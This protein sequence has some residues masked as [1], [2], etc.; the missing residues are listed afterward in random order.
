MPVFS[1][2]FNFDAMGTS[3]QHYWSGNYILGAVIG[4]SWSLYFWDLYL[5]RRQRN[6]YKTSKTIPD[7][8]KDVISPETF[9][10]SRKYKLDTSKY[11][12]IHTLFDQILDTSLLAVAAFPFLWNVS[13]KIMSKYGYGSHYEITQSLIFTGILYIITYA[14]NIPWKCYY[15]FVIEQKHGFNKMTVGFF[16]KDQFKHLALKLVLIP[17]ILAGMIH[18]IKIGGKYFYFYVWLFFFLLSLF[19]MA[20]YPTVIA[21]L[22]DKYTP[23]DQ[24]E[25][26]SKIEKLAS[27]LK[28]PLSQIFVVEGSK[29]SSH[30][31]AYFY[32][33]FKHKMIV[34]FDTI[35][36]NYLKK[37]KS[38]I[39]KLDNVEE[40]V[41]PNLAS[42]STDALLDGEKK[43]DHSITK[44]MTN[45]EILAVIAHELGHWKYS[46]TLKRFVMGQANFFF[47]FLVFSYLNNNQ[48]LYQAFGF[49]DQKP[50]LIGFLLILNC[51]LKP[52]EIV[53]EFLENVYSRKCEYDADAFATLQG[54]GQELITGLQQLH[55]EN[56]SFPT[57]DKLYSTW[58]FS[59]PSTVERIRTIRSLIAKGEGC[60]PV[61]SGEAYK[62]P[63][64]DC[65]DKKS[66]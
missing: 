16:I 53:M 4:F 59:H 47:S 38:I 3:L 46:H 40:L 63:Y 33:F 55:K 29:R 10:K 2:M 7:E 32:G 30:S 58:H 11:G 48:T 35:L 64:I 37:D 25:L 14:I 1:K 56:L 60:K 24:G 18:I 50:I 62:D 61:E 26:R 23:L 17:P 39:E 8:L 52:Y 36:P 44:T 5:D 22:F 51:F 27:K 31:N 65:F 49:Y 12:I 57:N 66:V 54:L 19:F 13:G 20:I 9:E 43:K 21:P 42:D 34:I 41:N 45:E 6:V 28:F 15:D